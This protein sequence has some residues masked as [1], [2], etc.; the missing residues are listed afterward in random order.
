M[1]SFTKS[2]HDSARMALVIPPYNWYENSKWMD[3]SSNLGLTLVV[4]MP[5]VDWIFIVMGHRLRSQIVFGI[6]DDV[7]KW[8][9]FPRYW[10]FMR[11][12][13]RWPVNSPHKG[14]WHGALMLRLICAWIN[15]WVNN[16][17]AG[18]LRRYRSHYDVI[19]IYFMH[20]CVCG[21]YLLPWAAKHPSSKMWLYLIQFTIRISNAICTSLRINK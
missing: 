1:W 12:V 4:M 2:L 10:P 5:P 20:D 16:R 18:D 13:H 7:I 17:E 9:H 8:K 21:W 19:V 6:H 14:Q 15:D 11:G 3:F